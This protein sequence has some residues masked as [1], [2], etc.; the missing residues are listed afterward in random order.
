MR[1]IDAFTI[2]RIAT[3]GH[4]IRDPQG[5]VVAWAVTEPWAALIAF[6]LNWVEA[7]GLQVGTAPRIMARLQTTPNVLT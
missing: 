5:R 1:D 3:A 4:E 6:C 7:E 2:R